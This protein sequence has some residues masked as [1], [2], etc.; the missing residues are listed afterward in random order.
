MKG[1]GLKG[2]CY[3]TPI[4]FQSK[5]DFEYWIELCLDYNKKVKPSK[6]NKQ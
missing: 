6:S 1:K 4:G 5:T 2:Y 3:V